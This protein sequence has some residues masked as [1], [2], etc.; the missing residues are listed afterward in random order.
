MLDTLDSASAPQ[1]NAKPT[2]VMSAPTRFSGRR[3]H[4]YRPTPTK[5]QPTNGP[6]IRVGTLLASWSLAATSHIARTPS[7]NPATP[8]P[9][10]ARL[11]PV[12]RAPRSEEHTSEL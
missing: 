7:A 1:K 12:T 10:R 8:M 2:A 9:H 6:R 3:H 4:A 11:R 5:L